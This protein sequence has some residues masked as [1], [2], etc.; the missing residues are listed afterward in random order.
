MPDQQS[1]SRLSGHQGAEGRSREERSRCERTHRESPRK[2]RSP[3]R[4]SPVR[5]ER[6]KLPL[7]SLQSGVTVG[8][9][10]RETAGGS[11][12]ERLGSRARAPSR[13]RGDSGRARWRSP[14]MKRVTGRGR[15]PLRRVTQSQVRAGS[16]AG[17]AAESGSVE[18]LRTVSLEGQENE[19]PKIPTEVRTV[20]VAVPEKTS[21]RMLE[22]PWPVEPAEEPAGNDT[23][24]AQCTA[25]REPWRCLRRH[26]HAID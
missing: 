16:S 22:E 12:G 4:R 17:G 21:P 18:E 8:W 1:R 2:D 26:V 11:S 19:A 6:R 20:I 15:P 25:C 9:S 23:E 24:L 13:A 14:E 5:R 3:R 7:R 10:V